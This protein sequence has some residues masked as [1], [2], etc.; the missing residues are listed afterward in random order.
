MPGF[1]TARLRSGDPSAAHLLRLNVS[2]ICTHTASFLLRISPLHRPFYPRHSPIAQTLSFPFSPTLLPFCSQSHPP[3]TPP[4]AP[5]PLYPSRLCPISHSRVGSLPFPRP[6]TR[7]PKRC[8][9]CV[10]IVPRLAH[11]LPLVRWDSSHSS[12]GSANH[13]LPLPCPFPMR[14]VSPRRC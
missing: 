7:S 3:S 5:F 13:H 11:V 4:Q 10:P 1:S 9:R 12:H 2:P 8:S 6:H 14:F